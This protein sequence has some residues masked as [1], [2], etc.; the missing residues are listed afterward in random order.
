M[1]WHQYV[2]CISKC[3]IDTHFLSCTFQV[4]RLSIFDKSLNSVILTRHRRVIFMQADCFSWFP[5]R[6]L[7]NGPAKHLSPFTPSICFIKTLK[8]ERCIA[9][10]FILTRNQKYS[11]EIWALRDRSHKDLKG[12]I[13]CKS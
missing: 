9:H 11:T 3:V 6:I 1:F 4:F 10:F 7:V 2:F 8:C 13:I 5:K 12:L